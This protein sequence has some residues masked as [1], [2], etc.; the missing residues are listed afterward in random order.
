MK[1]QFYYETLY[2]N[3]LTFS[4]TNITTLSTT[5]TPTPYKI[6]PDLSSGYHPDGTAATDANTFMTGSDLPSYGTTYEAWNM[7][8][9]IKGGF[10]AG[11]GYLTYLQSTSTYIIDLGASYT[12]TNFVF[13]GYH[14]HASY[15]LRGV[16]IYTSDDSAFPS[17]STDTFTKIQTTALGTSTPGYHYVTNTNVL[18]TWSNMAGRYVKVVMTGSSSPLGLYVFESEIWGY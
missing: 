18:S 11:K 12:I 6:S 17:G 7:F 10:A 8:D 3:D 16:E 15:A 9:G 13:Y 2:H 1:K 14:A 5:P 4:S